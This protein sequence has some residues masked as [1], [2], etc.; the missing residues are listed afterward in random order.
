MQNSI[1]LSSPAEDKH[2]PTMTA[3]KEAISDLYRRLG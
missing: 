3:F 1:N 2:L